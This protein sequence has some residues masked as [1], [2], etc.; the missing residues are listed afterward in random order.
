MRRRSALSRKANSLPDP[1]AAGRYR[2]AVEPVCRLPEKIQNGGRNV[3]QTGRALDAALAEI[4]MRDYQERPRF[5]RPQ[6]AMM[7][8]ADLRRAG[9]LICSAL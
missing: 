3:D 9:L 8:A 6:P 5:L 1:S 2:S 7:T 4:G